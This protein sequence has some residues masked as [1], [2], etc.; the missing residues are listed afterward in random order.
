MSRPIAPMSLK[1]P[2]LSEKRRKSPAR[3]AG[4][5][6]LPGGTGR[7]GSPG[8][9][10]RFAMA[11]HAGNDRRLPIIPIKEGNVA[12]INWNDELSV[13]VPSIDEEHK[14]LIGL[15]ND[16]YRD[17]YKAP[18]EDRGNGPRAE[19]LRHLSFRHRGTAHEPPE[20]PR[21]RLPL[22]RAPAF[23]EDGE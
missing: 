23:R 6:G 17:I 5:A 13:G 16:F 7:L 15:I 12:F 19:G 18:G 4:G 1:G 21:P 10:L 3:P 9:R 22:G 2:G 8:A 14:K 11:P 20:V